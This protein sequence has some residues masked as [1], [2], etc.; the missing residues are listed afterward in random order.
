MIAGTVRNLLRS[1]GVSVHR[2]AS[3]ERLYG[4]IYR[5]HGDIDRLNDDIARQNTVIAALNRDIARQ[6]TV[7]ATLNRDVARQNKVIAALNSYFDD[8]I[9]YTRAKIAAARVDGTCVPHVVVDNVLSP[10]LVQR[11]NANWPNPDAFAPEIVGNYILAMF[12]KSYDDIDP[13]VR[14][15]WVGF[16]EKLWPALVA[17]CAE[18]LAPV[19]QG[20]FGDLI[21]EYFSLDWPLTLMQG[22]SNYAGHHVHTHFWHA[23]HWA[24]TCLLYID[25]EE[26]VSNGTALHA[27]PRILGQ[28]LDEDADASN[29]GPHKLEQR[30]ETAMDPTRWAGADPRRAVDYSANRLFVFLDGPLALHS[31]L[32]DSPDGKPNPQRSLD[33]GLHARRRILRTHTKVHHAPFYEAHSHKL[34]ID[35]GADRYCYVM[36]PSRTLSAEDKAYRQE[37]VRAFYRERIASYNDAWSHYARDRRGNGSPPPSCDFGYEMFLK[38]LNERIP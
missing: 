11:I 5:L 24:F 26:T 30:V 17:S 27:V 38:Q 36:D 23:P 25:P 35:F 10:L 34:G 12:R 18:L 22:A 1:G 28:P 33:D 21:G 29:Y 4:D 14:D 6:D 3:I 2:T 7:I 37:T 8:C 9:K 19:M 13:A 32:E 16:N 15:F 20:V 31:V